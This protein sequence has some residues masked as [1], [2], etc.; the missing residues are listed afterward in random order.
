MASTPLL[1]I[2]HET[3]DTERRAPISPKD[4]RELVDGGLDVVVEESH[5]RIFPIEEYVAAGCRVA[6]GSWVDAPKDAIVVGL[7][8]L[9]AEP[10]ALTHRHVFFGHAYKGQNGATTLLRRFADGGGQLLDLE[11]LTDPN[12]RR[13][14]AFGYW[15]G[16][17]GAALAV[18]CRSDRIEP[19]LRHTSL[20]SL[21]DVV[22][23]AGA[24]GSTALV[25]G[26]QGRCGRGARAALS[27]AGIDPTCWDIEE[28]RNLDRAAILDHEILVNTV[29]V[30]E[31]TPPFLTH[32]ELASADR[33]LTVIAD[34][35]C[36]V[37]SE[38]NLLPIYSAVTSW[39]RPSVR[40]TTD[41]R[42]VDVIAIDNLPSILPLESS[43]AFSA[44]LAP[45]LAE[46][47]TLS[48]PWSRC[49]EHFS[50]ACHSAGIETERTN[51]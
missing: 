18:L 12:G 17:V 30:N 19:P 48:G 5:Q 7:K 31:P 51:A 2:R 50:R 38:F 39:E 41:S 9:P 28:T 37:S 34:V 44:E 6:A 47:H 24:E 16:Y 42:P 45:H 25:I 46:V 40:V 43:L 26:A 15:A 36:D 10:A 4:A 23:D 14:A 22:R 29:L 27:V 3:R 20:G 49:A 1:W 32:T 33:N 13:H 35:T 8:E 11:Y 21:D